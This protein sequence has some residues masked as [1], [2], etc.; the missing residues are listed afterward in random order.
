MKEYSGSVAEQFIREK[1]A[2]EVGV[3]FDLLEVFDNELIQ[4]VREMCKASIVLVD[5]T[6][7]GSVKF[8]AAFMSKWRPTYACFNGYPW[9]GWT[10]EAVD[11][12]LRLADRWTASQCG[13][14]IRVFGEIVE[15]KLFG[16]SEE[17]QRTSY[18]RGPSGSWKKPQTR[19]MSKGVYGRGMSVSQPDFQKANL[20]RRVEFKALSNAQKGLYSSRLTPSH[21]L[22]TSMAHAG[23]KKWAV[24]AND[25]TGKM[26][27]VFGLMPGATISG[28]TTDNM[29]FIGK[30]A[31]AVS[32]PALYLL[33]FGTIVSGGHHSLIEVALPLSTNGCID[34]SVGC[35]STLIPEITNTPAAKIIRKFLKLYDLRPE[36]RLMLVYYNGLNVDGCFVCESMPEK[37]T[38]KEKF[39][40]NRSLMEEFIALPPHPIRSRVETLAMQHGLYVG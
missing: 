31:Y 17:K 35:Y 27:E 24:M 40:V 9:A 23:A 30:F 32:D 8:R 36:N 39:K 37:V 1:Q 26:D 10:D 12:M 34:Y 22:M 7:G 33:P 20:R 19:N 16:K 29:Y 5:D 11:A 4:P 13:D 15:E 18:Q 25:T 6:V 3:S 2:M 14:W 38:W 21:E 28:T